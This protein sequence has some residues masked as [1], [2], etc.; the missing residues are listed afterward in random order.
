MMTAPCWPP[1]DP[2]LE[3]LRRL[4]ERAMVEE[5]KRKIRARLRQMGINPD[6]PRA[7]WPFLPAPFSQERERCV[8]VQDVLDKVG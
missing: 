6:Y 8:T 4:M 7:P 5:E 3:R 2:E 1:T